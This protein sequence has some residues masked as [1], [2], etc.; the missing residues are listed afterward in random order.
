MQ[1]HNILEKAA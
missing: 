1:M